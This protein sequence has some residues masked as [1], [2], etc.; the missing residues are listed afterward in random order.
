MLRVHLALLEQHCLR[1]EL[2]QLVHLNVGHRLIVLHH[3]DAW[4]RA[5]LLARQHIVVHSTLGS[6]HFLFK[7]LVFLLSN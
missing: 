1:V 5:M 2:A 7:V 4:L 3:L 6:V